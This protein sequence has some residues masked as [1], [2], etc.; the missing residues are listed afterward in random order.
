MREAKQLFKLKTGHDWS[1]NKPA[2]NGVKIF[3]LKIMRTPKRTHFVG[4]Y[5]EWLNLT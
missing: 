2:H 3:R 1:L 5:M 4:S